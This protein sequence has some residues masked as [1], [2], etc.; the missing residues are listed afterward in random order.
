MT[1]RPMATG[2]PRSTSSQAD[3]VPESVAQRVS[4]LSS[5]A[6]PGPNSA[7]LRYTFEAVAFLPVANDC[8]PASVANGA[9]AL[10]GRSNSSAMTVSISCRSPAGRVTSMTSIGLLD[11]YGAAGQSDAADDFGRNG[12]QRQRLAG[13]ALNVQVDGPAFAG[14]DAE[15]PGLNGP[16]RVP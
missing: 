6:F 13:P 16:P 15:P 3:F 1:P 11:G 4:L 10:A 9:M 7:M 8:E 5:K 2:L 12:R 14:R